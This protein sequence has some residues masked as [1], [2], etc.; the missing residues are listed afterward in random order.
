MESQ[1][2][3]IRQ[4]QQEMNEVLGQAAYGQQFEMGTGATSG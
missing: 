2:Q 4:T 1:D 3:V